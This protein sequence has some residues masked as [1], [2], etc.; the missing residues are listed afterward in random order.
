MDLKAVHLLMGQFAAVKTV[1]MQKV[2]GRPHIDTGTVKI[3]IEVKKPIP[4]I[5][6]YEGV[7]LT[8]GYRGVEQICRHCLE[9]GH[10]QRDCKA[11]LCENCHSR[12]HAA[13]NCPKPCRVC[14]GDHSILSCSAK[15]SVEEAA[16][17]DNIEMEV[18]TDASVPVSSPVNLPEAQ[19]APMVVEDTAPVPAPP[20]ETGNS[21]KVDDKI[22]EDCSKLD[23]RKQSISSVRTRSKTSRNSKGSEGESSSDVSAA[24]GS[25]SGREGRPSKRACRR[26]RKNRK[27]RA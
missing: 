14:T 19:A 4:N 6:Y 24:A 5:V 21:N 27:A 1:S 2:P 16:A 7:P 23:S 22:E 9:P 3:C 20:V 11:S 13:R 25:R 15:G 26:R 8:L 12:F 18:S 10:E 17:S